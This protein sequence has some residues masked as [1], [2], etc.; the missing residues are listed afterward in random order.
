MDKLRDN[1]KIVIGIAVAIV[2]VIVLFVVFGRDKDVSSVTNAEIKTGREYLASLEAGKVSDVE[3][4]LKEQRNEELRA[5]S[6]EKIDALDDE[7]T[8]IWSLFE[9]YVLLGDSRAVGFWY[10]GFL[11]KERAISEAGATIRFL[12]EHEPDIY[13]LN[14]SSIFCCFGLNDVSIGL[15]PTPEDYKAEYTETLKEIQK[16]LPDATIYVSSI[17]PAKDPAFNK[18][19][20]WR[21]IPQ[22]SEACK[23]MCEEN[24]FV[25]IDNSE[26]CEKY[27]DLWD[28][29]G[30][31]VQ[32]PF[33]NY[34][35]KNMI[36]ATYMHVLNEQLE[37]TSTDAD[38]S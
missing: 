37:A 26:I 33:Y 12:K 34:W 18:S 30:I 6:Q 10:Y 2:I 31:H 8:D 24:G 17:L 35:G 5:Q 21:N 32:K 14:P 23:E 16:Q 22:Y 20:K 29:D 3:N 13:A 19:E 27:T 1:L 7:N 38:E 36:L 4:I 9:D 28:I 11:P 15:W 25:Y